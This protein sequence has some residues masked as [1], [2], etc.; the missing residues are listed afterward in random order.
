MADD[1]TF[2]VRLVN[3]A[4]APARAIKQSIKEATDAF[5]AMDDAM[6]HQNWVKLKRGQAEAAKLARATKQQADILRAADIKK[7][8][9]GGFSGSALAL[10]T[11]EAATLGVAAAAVAAGAAELY[12]GKQFADAAIEAARFG[13]SSIHALTQLTGSAMTASRQFDA[14]RREAGD[15]ALNVDDTVK[16]FQKLLAAQFE[17]GK[18]KELI[19]MGADLQVIGASAEEVSRVMMAITQIKSKGKLQA[20]EMLQLQEAGISAELVY[21]ALGKRLGKTRDELGKLQQA[22]KID[23]AVGLEAIL[24]AVRQKTG[25]SKAGDAALNNKTIDASM[26]RLDA[27]MRNAMIDIGMA[28]EPTLAPLVARIPELFHAVMEDPAIQ[29]LGRQLLSGFEQFGLWVDANWPEIKDTVVGAVQ[30]MGD[31]IRV[32]FDALQWATDNA[33]GLKLALYALMVPV[34]LLAVGMLILLAPFYLAVAA[35]A[36]VAYGFVVAA[37]YI[38]E[39]WSKLGTSLTTSIEGALNWL[40]Q[41][42]QRFMQFG[43]DTVTGFITGVG[44]MA[45]AAWEAASALA[46]NVADGFKSAL[47]IASPS[48]LFEDFGGYTGEGF[49]LGLEGSMGRV[50]AANDNFSSVVAP[51]KVDIGA[52]GGG[53]GPVTVY[54]TVEAPPGATREDGERFGEGLRPVIRRELQ[55]IFAEEAA[56]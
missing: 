12:L 37:D 43:V 1:A 46:E 56:A 26:R 29:D 24:D 20:E 13:Q 8:G 52:G 38:S 55:A 25:T 42:P 14:V 31:V 11:L 22:G 3:E 10:G 39:N 7:A 17:I 28:I 36:A 51:G 41:L 19:R 40:T 2:A 50:N 33:D 48:K 49:A 6:A 54:L 15:L 35:I 47:G 5:K 44:S 45:E 53:R 27:D 21:E 16:S 30:F 23:A 4:T 18:A 32:Q 34:G 9:M